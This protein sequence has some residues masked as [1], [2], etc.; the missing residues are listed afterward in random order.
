MTAYKIVPALAKLG[1]VTVISER[2]H[3]H[4]HKTKP[5]IV[6]RVYEDKSGEIQIT[7]AKH[8][9]CYVRFALLSWDTNAPPFTKLLKTWEKDSKHFFTVK[10][11]VAWLCR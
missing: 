2:K 6:E 10:E 1:P 5:Y 11:A 9:G 7:V 8:H 4:G 3:H